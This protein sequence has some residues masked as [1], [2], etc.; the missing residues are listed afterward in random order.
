MKPS[1]LFI[2]TALL[3]LSC[4]RVERIIENTSQAPSILPTWDASNT[5]EP[6]V[7]PGIQTPS[8][9]NPTETPGLLGSVATLET[10]DGR[11][12][13]RLIIN[14]PYWE[15]LGLS[16]D[17]MDFWFAYADGKQELEG[18]EKKVL[19]DFLAQWESL[20]S[21]FTNSHFLQDSIVGYRVKEFPGDQGE[22][23]LVLYAIDEALSAGEGQDRLFL[24]THSSTGEKLS[25]SLAPEIEGLSQQISSDGN[26]VEYFDQKGDVLL[27]AD[28]IEFRGK[29]D[30]GKALK[31][32]LKEVYQGIS[33]DEKTAYPR[34]RFTTPGVDVGFFAIEQLTYYQI[35]L[36]KTALDLFERERLQGLAHHIFAEEKS[37]IIDLRMDDRFSGLASSGSD[38]AWL[39]P[40]KIVG[41][42]YSLAE[43]IAH[44][45]AHLL[46]E[47]TSSCDTILQYELA[48]GVIPPEIY[49]WSADELIE[50]LRNQEVGAYHVSLWILNALGVEDL[51]MVKWVILNGRANKQLLLVNCP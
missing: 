15:K 27:V 32:A 26:Y 4:S 50:A 30:E 38:I 43:V 18:S 10:M 5:T 14:S 45:G 19:E 33:Q 9:T 16:P 49:S 11:V 25:L 37:Y 3:L 28:A 2:L 24:T 42:R 1:A 46:Q 47:P 7:S 39:D 13:L 6:S 36:L 22:T 51:R 44:E 21:L 35:L 29:Q 40:E 34:F 41:N 23:R 8:D 31:K 20:N 17:K 12:A 48:D